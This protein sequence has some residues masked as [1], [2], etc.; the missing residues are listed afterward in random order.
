MGDLSHQDSRSNQSAVDDGV[1]F[2]EPRQRR[3][4]IVIEETL[5]DRATVLAA[6]GHHEVQVC[7]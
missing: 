6:T 5:V 1:V 4:G 2:N 7:L 3:I